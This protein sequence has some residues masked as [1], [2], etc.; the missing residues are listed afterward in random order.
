M[1]HTALSLASVILKRALK[2]IDYCLSREGW[3][4]SGVYTA[5]MMEEFVRLFRE[6]LSKVGMEAIGLSSERPGPSVETSW[7]STPGGKGHL[8]SPSMGE[9]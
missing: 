3:Q 5:A 2:T 4:E 8:G 1:K 9:W 7:V 6:A